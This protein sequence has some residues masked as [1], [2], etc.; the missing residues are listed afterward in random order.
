MFNIATAN[1]QTAYQ[2][3]TQPLPNGT[4]TAKIFTDPPPGQTGGSWKYLS[5]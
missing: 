1:P 4:F 3:I 2:Q 5:V